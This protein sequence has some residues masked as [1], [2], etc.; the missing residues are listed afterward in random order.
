MKRRALRKRYGR[1]S[2]EKPRIVYAS[3]TGLL[4]WNAPGSTQLQIMWPGPGSRL[5]MGFNVMK[6][7]SPYPGLIHHPGADGEY[8]TAKEAQAAVKRFFADHARLM[9]GT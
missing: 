2:G 4:V 8:R 7:G 3:P 5:R 6:A 1:S 9:S